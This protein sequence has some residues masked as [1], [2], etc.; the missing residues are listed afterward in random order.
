METEQSTLHSTSGRKLDHINLCRDV[1][2]ESKSRSNGFDQWRFDPT[3]LPELDSSTINTQTQL[4]NR[5]FSSPM[6]ITGMTGGVEKASIINQRLAAAAQK[7]NIPMGIGSQRIAI[8]DPSTATSFQVKQQ[9]PDIFLIGNLGIYQLCEKDGVSQ[10]LKAITSIQADA[11]AIHINVLQEQIQP[12][13]DKNLNKPFQQL[14]NLCQQSPVPI[15]VKEVGCGIDPKTAAKIWNT[16]VSCIDLGGVGGTSWGYIE[17]LRSSKTIHKRL[18]ETFR[19]WGIPT[20]EALTRN[21]KIFPDNQY[22]ATGGIRSGIE[23]AK[24]VALGAKTAGIGL[25]LFKAALIGETELFDEIE[26]FIAELKITMLL[27]NS[28]K[29]SDLK[30]HLRYIGTKKA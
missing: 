6:H 3:A 17:G 23:V 25:P 21:I 28:Q 11:L 10:A 12:E 7:Y 9:Y 16:G 26:A 20:A 22:T 1:N 18:G 8:K 4:L 15:I 30:Q 13:G 29:L 14:E 19:D 2:V 24:C 5:T 27:T